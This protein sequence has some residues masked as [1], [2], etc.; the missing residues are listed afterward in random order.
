MTESQVNDFVQDITARVFQI[1]FSDNTSLYNPEKLTDSQIFN[2]IR[3]IYIE[4]DKLNNSNPE[5]L[6][7]SEFDQLVKRTKEFLKTFKIEFDEDNIL[8]INDKDSNN[9]DY[10]PEPFLN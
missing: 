9:R 3:N 6:N 5:R 7:D 2:R 4:E 1:V 8:T 10:S